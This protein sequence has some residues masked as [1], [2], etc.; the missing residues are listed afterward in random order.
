MAGSPIT[1]PNIAKSDAYTTRNVG[2]VP[3]KPE[4]LL[5]KEDRRLLR[6]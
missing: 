6:E 2:L 5:T 3:V 1:L 4:D